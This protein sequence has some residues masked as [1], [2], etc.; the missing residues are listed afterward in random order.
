MDQVSTGGGKSTKAI[1]EPGWIRTSDHQL[2][3]Q[4]LYPLS[5][6]PVSAE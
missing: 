5:Y 3:R 2:R 1:G 4:V 6:G